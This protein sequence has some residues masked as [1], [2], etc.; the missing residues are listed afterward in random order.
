VDKKAG[1][2]KVERRRATSRSSWRSAMIIAMERLVI[3]VPLTAF[4][5]PRPYYGSRGCA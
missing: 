2:L 4:G 1:I 3:G 5:E